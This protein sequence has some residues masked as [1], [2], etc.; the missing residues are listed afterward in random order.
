MAERTCGTY[1]VLL[2]S[3]IS[4]SE[5]PLAEVYR[6]DLLINKEMWVFHLVMFHMQSTILL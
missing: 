1:L 3:S 4:Q 2:Y 5:C 6:L